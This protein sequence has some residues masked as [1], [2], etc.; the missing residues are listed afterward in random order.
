MR[1][2]ALL[3]QSFNQDSL[4]PVNMNNYRR[5]EFDKPSNIKTKFGKKKMRYRYGPPEKELRYSYLEEEYDYFDPK[6]T[7]LS[8]KTLEQLSDY[9]SGLTYKDFDPKYE[10]HL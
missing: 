1:D 6:I 7:G 2:Q 4:Y 5:I 9:K 10:G 8:K 3:E